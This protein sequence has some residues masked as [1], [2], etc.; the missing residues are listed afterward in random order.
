MLVPATVIVVALVP[1]ASTLP[2]GLESVAESLSSLEL[3]G[4]VTVPSLLAD[5]AVPGITSLPMAT[6]LAG[7][8]GIALV[9]GLASLVG[10]GHRCSRDIL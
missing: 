9:Y 1:F 6:V 8:L 4:A 7:L 5:Y 3:R 10:S 2:D